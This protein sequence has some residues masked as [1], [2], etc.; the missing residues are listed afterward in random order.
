MADKSLRI[1]LIGYGNVGRELMTVLTAGAT[2]FPGL[3]G[4]KPVIVGVVTRNHG[5]I[6]RPSGFLPRDVKEI[7]SSEQTF[8]EESPYFSKLPAPGAVSSLEYDVLVELS[9]LS[10]ENRGNPAVEYVRQALV[11]GRHVVTANKGPAAFAYR[12]L[13]DTARGNGCLFLHEAAVM[14]G[15]PVFNLVRDALPGCTV[16]GVSGILNST[17][18]F[19]LGRMEEGASISTAV[20]EAQQLGFAEADPDYDLD[21]WDAAAKTA[22]LA[23]VLFNADIDPFQVTREGIGAVDNRQLRQAAARGRR[24]KLVCRA[25]RDRDGIRAEVKLEEIPVDHPFAQVRGSGSCIRLET[26]FMSPLVIAQE[27]PGIRDTAYGVVADLIKVAEEMS[28]M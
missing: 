13:T 6:V 12:E 18:N 26:D 11:R 7:Y 17:T 4:L 19:V 10:V 23:N 9:V 5:G 20:R 28:K 21:G 8:S 25:G 3:D 14:D 24:I 16:T 22:V 27:Q 15:A 2:D 1:L